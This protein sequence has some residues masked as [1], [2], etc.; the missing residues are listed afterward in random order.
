[1]QQFRNLRSA[2]LKDMFSLVKLS[3]LVVLRQAADPLEERLPFA[4]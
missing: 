3:A 2:R 1:M 4:S